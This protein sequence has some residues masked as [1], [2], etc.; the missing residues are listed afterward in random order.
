MAIKSDFKEI[1]NLRLHF[2]GDSGIIRYLTVDDTRRAI[3]YLIL[4]GN[5]EPLN[6]EPLNRGPLNRARE[7]LSYGQN[8]IS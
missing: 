8:S 1:A 6:R 2:I 3:H 4:P 7:S 5:R